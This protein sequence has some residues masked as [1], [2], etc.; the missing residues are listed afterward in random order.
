MR[1]FPLRLTVLIPALFLSTLSLSGL[2]T[3]PLFLASAQ[4]GFRSS[5]VLPEGEGLL[6]LNLSTGNNFIVEELQSNGT[7]INLELDSEAAAALV[8]A[9]LVSAAFGTGHGIELNIDLQASVQYG[10]FMD[11]LIQGFH[12]LFGFPDGSRDLREQN[13][14]RFVMFYG[15]ERILDSEGI[16]PLSLHLAVEPR[17]S[18]FQFY[19]HEDREFSGA[20]GL[21]GAVPLTPGSHPLHHSGGIGALQG[22]LRFYL[23]GRTESFDLG[24]SAGAVS[25]AKPAFLDD[26]LFS[27]L[28]LVCDASAAWKAGRGVR[29]EAVIRGSSSPFSIGYRRTDNLSAVIELG[30]TMELGKDAVLR[31]GCIEEF[32]TFAASDI[33]FFIGWKKAFRREDFRREAE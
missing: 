9:A 19:G 21:W 33:G 6:T 25:A 22:G 17:I 7:T 8:S 32:F 2:N 29:L 27:P 20:L 18:L 31:F 23:A 26:E 1:L 4:P 28:L 12:G 30:G 10:G 5:A 15:G 14:A 13:Q 11:P 3:H 16:V 24:L